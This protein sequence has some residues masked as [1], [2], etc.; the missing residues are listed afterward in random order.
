MINE[1]LYFE[2]RVFREFCT[3]FNKDHRKANS[4]F[5]DYGIWDY[6]ESCY[7]TLH[8]SGDDCV[9]EDISEILKEKGV[10]L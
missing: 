1:L 5:K 7:D 9:V 8:M 10:A 6:I 3:R 2:A 4:L